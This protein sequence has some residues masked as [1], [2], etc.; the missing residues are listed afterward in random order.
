MKSLNYHYKNK[1]LSKYY[2]VI[3][4]QDNIKVN[5]IRYN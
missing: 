2:E 3:N 5:Y 1:Y 4:G